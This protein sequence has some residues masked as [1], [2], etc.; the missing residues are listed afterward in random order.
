MS[1]EGQ[2]V[3]YIYSCKKE[4]TVSHPWNTK[5]EYSESDDFNRYYPMLAKFAS[6]IRGEAVNPYTPDYEL[7]LYKIVLKA[8]GIDEQK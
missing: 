2:A 3:Y 4:C 1:R 6:Y 7:E 8:C 5:G